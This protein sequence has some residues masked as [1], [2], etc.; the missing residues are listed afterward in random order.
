M[1][2]QE[3]VNAVTEYLQKLLED[4]AANEAT[5]ANTKDDVN[6]ATQSLAELHDQLEDKRTNY[7]SEIAVL[8]Q[9]KS[10]ESFKVVAIEKQLQVLINKKA[11][12]MLENERLFKENEEFKE[13][14]QKATKVLKA[15]EASILEREKLVKEREG[16]RVNRTILPV[17]E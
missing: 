17:K 13:Y 11:E 16:L 3:H 4:I 6:E 9:T 1:T 10:E 2:P 12:L 8:Q 14:E 15:T 5:L 7:N